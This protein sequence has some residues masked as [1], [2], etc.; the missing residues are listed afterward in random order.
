[1][2]KVF[3][4]ELKPIPDSEDLMLELP[5]EVVDQ[6]QLKDG[7]TISWTDLGDGSFRLSRKE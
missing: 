5:Q 6:L 4:V 7:D 1:M 2:S 3:T